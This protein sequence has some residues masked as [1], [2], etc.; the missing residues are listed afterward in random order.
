M[1]MAMWRLLAQGR[2]VQLKR[3]K[4]AGSSPASHAHVAALLDPSTS[5]DRT[6]SSAHVSIGLISH[7]LDMW[8]ANSALDPDWYCLQDKDSKDA[9]QKLITDGSFKVDGLLKADPEI[10]PK[11]LPNVGDFL[12]QRGLGSYKF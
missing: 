10:D 7:F 5:L 12:S 9:L 8:M 6:D 4:Q 1:M 11:D 3:K 2:T